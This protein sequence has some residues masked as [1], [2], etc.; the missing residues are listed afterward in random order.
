MDPGGYKAELPTHNEGAIS[1]ADGVMGRD[2]HKVELPAQDMVEVSGKEIR[3]VHEL[4][5]NP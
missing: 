4:S 3:T 5:S 2:D 1:A